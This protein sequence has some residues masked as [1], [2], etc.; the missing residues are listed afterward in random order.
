MLNGQQDML[1]S[2]YADL[3]DILIKPVNILKQGIENAT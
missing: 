2:K 3:Y 1:I